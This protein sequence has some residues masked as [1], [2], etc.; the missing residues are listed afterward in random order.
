[1]ALV[2]IALTKRNP[3]APVFLMG[4]PLVD[5]CKM[6]ADCTLFWQVNTAVFLEQ[7]TADPGQNLVTHLVGQQVQMIAKPSVTDL[8]HV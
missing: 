5:N 1:M 6:A 4:H 7:N 2:V 3:T 8:Q